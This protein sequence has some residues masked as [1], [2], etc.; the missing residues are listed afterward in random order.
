MTVSVPHLTALL[1]DLNVEGQRIIRAVTRKGDLGVLNKKANEGAG[2]DDAQTE[3]DRRVEAHVLRATRSFCPELK[4]VAEESYENPDAVVPAEDDFA[5]LP[6]FAEMKP[7]RFPRGQS[8]VAPNTRDALKAL[9][10]VDGFF[11]PETERQ[12][13]ARAGRT[14]AGTAMQPLDWPPHLL[15]PIDARRVTVFVDP[16]DGTN[17]FAA[18]A[19]ECVTCL[20]G[21]AVD[22]SPVVGIIGQ[23]FYSRAA[24]G[25]ADAECG[26]DAERLGR[27]VWGGRGLG[28]L[29]LDDDARRGV[30]NLSTRKFE[31]ETSSK[32]KP[33]ACAVNRGAANDPLVDVALGKIRAVAKY[34]VSATGFHFLLL[35]EKKADCALLLRSGTKKWDSC[36]GDALLRAVGGRV[37]D[38][39]GRLY[40][41]GKP[42]MALNLSGLIST[43]DAEILHDAIV[44][45]AM[46]ASA[47]SAAVPFE[48][49]GAPLNCYPLNVSDGSIRERILPTAPLG[50]WRALTV[51]VGGCLLTP[52]EKV[53]KT[54]VRVARRLGLDETRVTEDSVLRAIRY[55]FSRPVPDENPKG[56][57]YVGDGKS[58]WRPL[59]RD[60]LE[61]TFAREDGGERR[62]DRI[63]LSDASVEMA[64]DWLYERYE[65]PD[66]WHVAPGEIEA[67]RAL[68]TAGIRV[69]VISNWDTRLPMLLRKCG[70]DEDVLDAVVVSAE[71]HADKPDS[72]IFEIALDRLN[73][74]FAKSSDAS[75]VLLPSHCLHVGDSSVNDVSGAFGAGFGGALLWNSA[76]REG[77]AFD[78]QEVACEILQTRRGAF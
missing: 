44:A 74:K 66:S 60:A 14:P 13:R 32:N 58:F 40:D 41:Y 76:L 5:D 49:G 23:P 19:R 59:V 61:G 38:A 33:L 43:R 11:P 1:L 18:G 6:G 69:A 12:A 25:D 17:E 51:D 39:A 47:A 20:M 9:A 72:K 67:F 26:S 27:V 21:V 22:G 7:A 31:T 42:E 35:L 34:E 29:G 71:V 57:R 73:G 64:L 70:F 46:E 54:Y 62:D 56:V 53:T 63:S 50:G 37:T 55:G 4:V 36:P 52:K 10:G 28:V 45:A 65:Q 77:C 30:G 2:A 75:S 3:A 48:S 24:G 8:D 78:F 68:R 15:D 16:L